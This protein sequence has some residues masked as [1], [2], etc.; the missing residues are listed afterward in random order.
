MRYVSRLPDAA[1]RSVSN[2]VSGFE[3]GARETRAAV[4]QAI[5]AVKHRQRVTA[6][7]AESAVAGLLLEVEGSLETKSLTVDYTLIPRESTRRA[8]RLG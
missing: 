6:A 2:V 4:Q 8:R 1:S 3:H 7:I 5:G